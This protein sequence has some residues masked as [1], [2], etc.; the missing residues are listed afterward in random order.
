ML[1]TYTH[2]SKCKKKWIYFTIKKYGV[3]ELTFYFHKLTVLQIR[4]KPNNNNML[5]L[6]ENTSLKTFDFQQKQH[7]TAIL[8]NR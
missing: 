1:P 7:Q 8:V 6:D 3:V 5:Y 2:Y 4:Q